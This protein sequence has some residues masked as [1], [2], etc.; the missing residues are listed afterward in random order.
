MP[1]AYMSL[2]TDASDEARPGSEEVYSGN[3]EIS[4]IRNYPKRLKI[5]CCNI[6]ILLVIVATIIIL[7]G[8]TLNILSPVSRL[9]GYVNSD[10]LSCGNS[11]AEA[12]AAGCEFDIMSFTW[13]PEACFDR[14]LMD[15]FLAR[16]NWTWWVNE[17]DEMP[18]QLLDVQYGQYL[19]LF[20]TWEYHLFHCTYMWKKMHRAIRAGRPLDSYIANINHTNHCEMMLLDHTMDL[21]ARSTIIAVKYPFCP[22]S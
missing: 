6:T 20:V 17:V 12:L 16:K 18:L 2:R 4:A 15:D 8:G 10:T 3:N 1:N 21:D 19:Q 11:S 7:A 9:E 14:E 22:G 5:S 13:S